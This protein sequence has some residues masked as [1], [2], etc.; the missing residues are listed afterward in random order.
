M[1]ARR[2]PRKLVAGGLSPAQ[3]DRPKVPRTL[4][5]SRFKPAVRLVDDVH[6]A[7]AANDPAIAMPALQR[8]QGVTN[9]HRAPRLVF[10]SLIVG[11][12]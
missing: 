1:V 10:Q 9:F 4:A 11:G 5:L 8:L 2:R 3:L 6:A 7:A 12:C